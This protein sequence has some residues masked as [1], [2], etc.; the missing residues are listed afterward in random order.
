MGV[1]QVETVLGAVPTAELGATLMH[2]HVFVLTADS[3]AN[4][5]AGAWDE[6]E[7]V[8]DAVRRLRE[9]RDAGITTLVDPTVDGLGRDVPRIR[10]IAERVPGLNIIVATGIYTYA[11]V[12]GYFRFR[13]PGLLPGLPE[14]MVELFVRDIRE[15]IQGTDS[16]AAFIKCAIDS[17]GLTPGVERVMRAAAGAHRETGVPIM[18]HTHPRSRTGLAVRRVLAEEGVPPGRVILAHSGDTTDADHLTELAESGFILGMDRFGIDVELPFE[19]RVAIVA[20]MARRGY[21]DRMVLSQD[22]AC[23]IDWV[24]PDFLP[25][26]PN[27]NYLHV[28]RDVVPAL[29]ERGLDEKDIDAM[30]VRTPRAW[31]ERTT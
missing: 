24:Q 25:A 26:L 21:A 17:H 19:D 10:R 20:E 1:T 2:E 9:V 22:T 7:R 29:R 12:P 5:E 27:W 30:L 14:P 31:F 3:Q 4:W 18:V 23:L 8:A 15:G 16:K 11:D 13:G 28:L 6:E